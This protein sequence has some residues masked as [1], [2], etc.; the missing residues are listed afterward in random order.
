M[1]ALGVLALAYFRATPPVIRAHA[2][3]NLVFVEILPRSPAPEEE[4]AAL[5]GDPEWIRWKGLSIYHPGA[6]LHDAPVLDRLR[7]RIEY[8]AV[9][10][11]YARRPERLRDT[12]ERAAAAAFTLRPDW[13]NFEKAAGVPY[14]TRATRRGEW[15]ALREAVFPARLWWIATFF[16]AILAVAAAIAVRGARVEG[17][18]LGAVLATA[19][20]VAVTDFLVCALANAH[21][22]LQRHLFVFQAA[23][24]LCLIAGLA[25][26]A[27]GLRAVFGRKIGPR[28]AVD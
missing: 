4:L 25:L 7:E 8:R 19:S 5:G 10:R 26:A 18:L 21:I 17:R 6:P 1:L 27:L 12:L 11:F 9:A 14:G 23:H 15:S 13:G 28:S 3:F 16:G 20:L 24:D 22:E 2:I